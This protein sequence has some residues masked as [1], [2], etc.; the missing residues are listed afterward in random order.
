MNII[1]FGILDWD[2]RFQ[3]PQQIPKKLATLG[4]N[5]Y[6]FNPRT[7]A[8]NS[9]PYTFLHENQNVKVFRLASNPFYDT[10]YTKRLTS[11]QAINLAQVITNFIAENQISNPKVIIQLPFWWDAVKF[12]PDL[13]VFYDCMD[14]HSG[15]ETHSLE[16]DCVELELAQ[17]CSQLFVSSRYL[18]NKYNKFKPIIIRNGCDSSLFIQHDK[19]KKVKKDIGYF[20]AIDVWF[21]E[22]LVIRI[23]ENLPD[24]NIH[25]IGNINPLVKEKLAHIPNILMYGERMHS[26]IPDLTKTWNFALI[27]FKIN[28]LTKA[29]D[30]VKIYEYAALGIQTIS[31]KLPE[32]SHIPKN[33]CYSVDDSD[34]A[35][36][37]LKKSNDSDMDLLERRFFATENDWLSRAKEIESSLKDSFKYSFVILNYNNA[38]HTAKLVDSIINIYSTAHEIIIVDNKSNEEDLKI[39]EMINKDVECIKLIKNSHNNGFSGG[40]NIGI[41]ESSG[42]YIILCNNDILFVMDAINPMRRALERNP[43]IGAIGPTTNN[44]GNEAYIR[45]RNPSD[46]SNIERIKNLCL[47]NRNN[48]EYVNNLGFFCVMF[49]NESVAKVGKLDEN[50]GIGYFEDDDYCARIRSFGYKI[51]LCRESFVFHMG[52]ATFDKEQ[53]VKNKSE[54]FQRNKQIYESK[55]GSWIPHTRSKKSYEI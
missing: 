36:E 54:L 45:V 9:V 35:I 28:S 19:T 43:E 17:N 42:E 23:A 46:L 33:I 44:V 34:Q 25:L 18:A 6:Y 52:S 4:H 32:L 20:G 53:G 26:E 30:P 48:V 49:P 10:P 47:E 31:T 1:I 50:F 27:P 13:D 16:L 24:F 22:D 55:W 37:F 5:I 38:L 51:A 21:D 29:T 15:F 7:Y 40:M 41:S 14:D 3:R 11:E 2:D 39:L 12:V 8:A